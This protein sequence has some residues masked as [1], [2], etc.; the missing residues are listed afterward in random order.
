MDGFCSL[1][2]FHG[3]RMSFT[4]FRLVFLYLQFAFFVLPVCLCIN[5]Q[6]VAFPSSVFHDLVITFLPFCPF[7]FL[8]LKL[9]HQEREPVYVFKRYA[10]SFGYA[11][12]RVFGHVELYAHL[13]GKSLV[14]SSQQGTATTE[15]NSVFHD[16]GIKLGRS[17]FKRREYC[18]LY[19]GYRLEIGRASCRERV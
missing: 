2:G 14:E 17:V 19:L 9:S 12:Q 8:S 4:Y 16:V 11:V 10:R 7:T 6:S 18:A 13:V 5:F 15:V 3:F 1:Y